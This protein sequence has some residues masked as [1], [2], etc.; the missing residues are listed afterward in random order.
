MAA[1]LAADYPEFWPETVR[2]LIVHS[3]EWTP[4]MKAELRGA[5]GAKSKRAALVRRY[6]FGLPDLDRAKR[7]AKDSLT[8]ISQSTIHQFSEGSLREM[9]VHELPW[10]KGALE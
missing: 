8:L 10:P 5:Q 6:G 4:T 2:A 1:I 9:N 3:A 7:S